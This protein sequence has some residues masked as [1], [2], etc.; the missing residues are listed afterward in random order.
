MNKALFFL[1]LALTAH[2]LTACGGGRMGLALPD[3]GGVVRCP[4]QYEPI[5]L[6][7]EESEVTS[8]L[9]WPDVSGEETPLLTGEYEYQSVEFYIVD[10]ETDFRFHTSE[11]FNDQNSQVRNL[12][13]RN[14]MAARTLSVET[15]FPTKIRV[16][17]SGKTISENKIISVNVS[18]RI[19]VTVG[20]QTEA[21]EPPS[22]VT[23]DQNYSSAL[24]K[25]Q[26]SDGETFFELRMRDHTGPVL[27]NLLVI[28]KKV[29]E[30]AP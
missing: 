19:D 25:S 20:E 15:E 26:N 29:G 22:K 11:T 10:T 12:C 28:Y 24:Y 1:G 7:V 18:N 21:A 5:S 6:D 23:G 8:K 2:S 30:P 16:L 3:S 27:R 9:R 14:A 13:G 17:S 4:Q